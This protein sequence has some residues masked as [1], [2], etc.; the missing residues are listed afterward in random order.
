V[1]IC[2]F[3]ALVKLNTSIRW[4]RDWLWRRR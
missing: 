3:R 4:W 1:I 2:K